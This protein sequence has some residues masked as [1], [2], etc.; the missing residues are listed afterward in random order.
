MDG[1]RMHFLQGDFGKQYFPA[2]TVSS[3]TLHC[4]HATLM[5][6]ALAITELHFS[7]HTKYNHSRQ[8]PFVMTARNAGDS[9][10][11]SGSYKSPDCSSSKRHASNLPPHQISNLHSAVCHGQSNQ[12]KV[13]ILTAAP[14]IKQ[15]A[16]DTASVRGNSQRSMS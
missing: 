11:Q 2:A 8:L 4:A 9:P 12:P 6:F 7:C 13:S 16:G 14:K 1:H 5:N 15:H 3:D 10:Q